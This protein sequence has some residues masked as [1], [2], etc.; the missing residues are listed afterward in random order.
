MLVRTDKKRDR[1]G[2]A[3]SMQKYRDADYFSH[4]EPCQRT[5]EVVNTVFADDKPRARTFFGHSI[6]RDVGSESQRSP[7][8]PLKDT[9]AEYQHVLATSDEFRWRSG[10]E[11]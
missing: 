6:P 1:G 2:F 9:K 11:G 3:E 4:C 8:P 5:L 7:Q 10:G